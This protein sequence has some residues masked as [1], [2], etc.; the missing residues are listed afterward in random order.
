MNRREV[1]ALF[2]GA[3]VGW[4]TT[5]RAQQTNKI[6]RIGVLGNDPRLPTTAAGKA[7]LEGLKAN[8]F[9]ER[10]NILID[11]RFSEGKVDQF[12][13][14]ATTLAHLQMNLIVATSVSAAKAAIDAT[15]SIPIVMLNV[16]DP[17]GQGLVTSLAVP[18]GNITGLTADLSAQL[19]TKRLQLIKDAVQKVSQVAV[20]VNPEEPYSASQQKVLEEAA[21]SLGITLQLV[22]V[23]KAADFE[24]AFDGMV[25][26]R[27]DAL[28]VVSGGTFLLWRGLIT[29][30]AAK[31]QLPTI[32]TYREITEAGGL[33]SYGIDRPDLFRRA[34]FYVAK[35]LQGAKPADLPIEQ[36][37]KFEFVVNLK[38]AKALGIAIPSGVLSIADEVIE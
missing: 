31:F 29:E 2:G 36:P 3:A 33:L 7:L 24:G 6:Y 12:A 18:G 30:L 27:P 15:K 4:P 11:W 37:T 32:S 28:F 23:R 17:V 35:I 22:K 21:P 14:L 34:A 13:A 38:T 25:R 16:S 1:V 19:A 20:L 10:N 8:G 9:V 26:D 5:V